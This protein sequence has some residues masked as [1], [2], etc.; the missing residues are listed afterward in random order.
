MAGNSTPMNHE[1]MSSDEDIIQA[2][3]YHQ[4]LRQRTEKY[5]D[6][7]SSDSDRQEIIDDSDEDPDFVSGTPQAPR[8]VRNVLLQSF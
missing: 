7:L 1:I 8:S 6:L 2:S 3:C 4:R 5:N